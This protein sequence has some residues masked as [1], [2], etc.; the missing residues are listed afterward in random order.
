MRIPDFF[1]VGAPKCGTTALYSYL[2]QHSAV[3]M[4]ERKEPR[5]FATDLDCGSQREG[6]Y[7]VRDRDAYLQLFASAG[8]ALRIGEA[9]PQYLY[10]A[11]AAQN[12]KDFC[13][14]AKII[15]LVRDPVELMYAYHWQR[16]NDGN[17]DIEDFGEA[18]DAERERKQGG[19][20]PPKCFMAKALWYREV[21][22]LSYQI[23]RFMAIYPAEDLMVIVYD[24]MKADTPA[25][26]RDVLRFLE[27]D[28]GF[29]PELP[30]VNASKHVRSKWVRDMLR[31][32][33]AVVLRTAR[34]LL[35]RGLRQRL[36]A[37]L[38]RRNIVQ[39]PRRPMDP[40]L[41]RRLQAEFAPE[42][43][44]LGRLIGRDLTA[45]SRA[46]A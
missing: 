31:E 43:E 2:R 39:R 6:R 5:F 9:S 1:I 45:W 26:Y 28:D 10:S 7:F 4:P 30:V 14:K 23:E 20:I 16:F 44:R 38:W 17:E 13:D 8:M 42:V 29:R 3:F 18:L 21:A 41:R 36:V 15:A 35:P 34:G 25:V 33:P 12:I 32:P 19:R 40:A 37:Q 11:M 27:V 24:D 46:P 22:T